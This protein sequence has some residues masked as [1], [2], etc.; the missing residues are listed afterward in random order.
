M[1]KHGRDKDP[2][3]QDLIVA[4][5]HAALYEASPAPRSIFS[6]LIELRNIIDVLLRSKKVKNLS[7]ITVAMIR[8]HMPMPLTRKRDTGS[9]YYRHWSH[10]M[11]DKYL[12][13]HLRAAKICR[14]RDIEW[15]LDKIEYQCFNLSAVSTDFILKILRAEME[16]ARF[17]E[18][19]LRRYLTA[20]IQEHCL[21]FK[22]T[23]DESTE[24][25]S[26]LGKSVK[27]QGSSRTGSSTHDSS[28]A[29][30]MSS[31][32]REDDS[33]RSEGAHRSKR[34]RKSGRKQADG[35]NHEEAVRKMR[36]EVAALSKIVSQYRSSCSGGVHKYRTVENLSDMTLV[37][38][39]ETLVYFNTLI[40]RLEG[41]RRTFNDT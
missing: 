22:L 29:S 18:G 2:T 6:K 17:G 31:R 26:I 4:C 5:Q 16:K 3:F 34:A 14:F 38:M 19:V 20:V 15:L 13:D 7:A 8:E 28:G 10:G 25:N 30:G 24:M 11:S 21:V 23:T 9:P 41:N 32:S 27:V 35:I 39:S 36:Q 33:S 1:D 12:Q 40:S 37:E